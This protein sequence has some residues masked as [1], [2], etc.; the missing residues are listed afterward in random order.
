MNEYK[1]GLSL[2]K[3]ISKNQKGLDARKAFIVSQIKVYN[4]KSLRSSFN[5]KHIGLGENGESDIYIT[6]TTLIITLYT[7][8]ILN[9]PGKAVRL[10][11]QL[12]RT[13]DEPDNLSDLL[14]NKKLFKTFKVAS[15]D[16]GSSGVAESI[17]D[18]STVSDSDLIKAI[19]DY[20]CDQQDFS[21]KKRNAIDNMKKI[22]IES[23]LLHNK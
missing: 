14:L 1:I 23:G 12:L 7:E 13:S 10:L 18:L 5:P 17:V 16:N 9:T 22:A 21:N 4:E 8:E 15:I 11:S 2:V 19:V 6:R 20:V 3:N